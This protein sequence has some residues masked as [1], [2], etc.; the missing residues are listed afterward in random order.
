MVSR[1]DIMV[2]VISEHLMN[3]RIRKNIGGNVNDRP[4]RSLHRFGSLKLNH[5][6]RVVF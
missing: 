5:V 2:I 1:K 6:E 4:E 3:R